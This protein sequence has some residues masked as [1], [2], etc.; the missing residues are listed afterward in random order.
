MAKKGQKFN[1]YTDN[2]RQKYTKFIVENKKSYDEVVEKDGVS[3][4]I[5][6]VW[7]KKV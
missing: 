2:E 4:G 5:L 3:K 1:K 6:A 7:V